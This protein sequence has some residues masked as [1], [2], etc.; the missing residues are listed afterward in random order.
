MSGATNCKS[1]QPSLNDSGVAGN[2]RSTGTVAKQAVNKM[3]ETDVLLLILDPV[4]RPAVLTGKLFEYLRAQK[5]IL[6]LA[7]KNSEVAKIITKYQVGEVIENLKQLDS[8]VRVEVVGRKDEYTVTAMI[9]DT[10]DVAWF[11][12]KWN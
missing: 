6:A 9:K 4:E 11:K 2:L 5:P 12:L 1:G 3:I 8:F 7:Y 10:R